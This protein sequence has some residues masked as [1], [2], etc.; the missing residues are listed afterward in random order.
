MPLKLH[1][2]SVRVK[3]ITASG[4]KIF[5]IGLLEV[6]EILSKWDY[7]YLVLKEVVTDCLVHAVVD[8]EIKTLSHKHVLV[9]VVCLEL[10]I[11]VAA[12]AVPWSVA[13]NVK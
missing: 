10:H 2:E 8:G 13:I 3:T 7:S 11:H 4:D 1:D 6:K 5:F 12:F 9:F